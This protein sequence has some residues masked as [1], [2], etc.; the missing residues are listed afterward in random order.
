MM[1]GKLG[2]DEVRDGDPELFARLEKMLVTTR[3]DMTIFYQLLMSMPQDEADDD[4]LMA[5]F[6]ESFYVEPDP[7]Q[8]Q[9]MLQVLRQIARRRAAVADVEG[10]KQRMR[11]S[12]PRII[13]R[14]YLLH[15]SIEELENSSDTLFRKLEAAMKDPY[16]TNGH[17]ELTGKR[18]QWATSKAGCSMLSCSS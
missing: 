8:N 18:P 3:P 7:G 1:A 16:S 10:S 13:L 12:N 4:R 6:K 9:E 11:R 5:H 14:N 17:E 15:Q 2:L